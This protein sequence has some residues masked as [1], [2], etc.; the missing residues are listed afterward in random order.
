MFAGKFRETDSSIPKTSTKLSKMGNN[1][2]KRFFDKKEDADQE[3]REWLSLECNSAV[4]SWSSS[5]GK[6]LRKN[7][8]ILCQQYWNANQSPGAVPGYHTGTRGH[9]VSTLAS[10]AFSKSFP[11]QGCSKYWNFL[12]EL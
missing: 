3:F 11:T 6:P 4:S 7:V 12:E 5:R 9:D 1:F 2:S 8:K 10:A